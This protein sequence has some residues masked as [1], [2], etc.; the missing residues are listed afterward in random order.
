M[1]EGSS[2]LLA[3]D[4]IVVAHIAAV[5]HIAV[6]HIAVGRTAVVRT[7]ADRIAVAVAGGILLRLLSCPSVRSLFHRPPGPRLLPPNSTPD[8][9]SSSGPCVERPR[10]AV[11]LTDYCKTTVNTHITFVL[12]GLTSFADIVRSPISV[13]EASRAVGCGR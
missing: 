13:Y 6:D 7:A 8:T 4:H 9:S 10:F 2:L 12:R 1:L 5:V 11:S 3:V